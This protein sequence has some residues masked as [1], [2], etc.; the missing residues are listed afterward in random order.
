MW[1]HCGDID[2]QEADATVSVL[3]FGD[4]QC[5]VNSATTMCLVKTVTSCVGTITALSL[6][7]LVC[8]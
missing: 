4:C 5:S 2:G 8:H 7:M 6:Q 1:C 3:G